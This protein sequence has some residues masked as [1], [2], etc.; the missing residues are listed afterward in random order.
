[1]KSK[2]PRFLKPNRLKKVKKSISN[3]KVEFNA[4]KELEKDK[5][6]RKQSKTL[7]KVGFEYKDRKD[8]W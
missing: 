4:R 6:K 2:T 8:V 7:N 3:P 1:M 5:L